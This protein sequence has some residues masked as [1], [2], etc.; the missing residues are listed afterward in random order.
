VKI[1]LILIAIIAASLLTGAIWPEQNGENSYPV[2]KV[3]IYVPSKPGGTT[4]TTARA[5]ARSL[6][7]HTGVKALVINQ[8]A[9]GGTVAVS[10]VAEARPD[11]GTLLLFH[12]MLHVSNATG[13]MPVSADDLTPLATISRASDVYVVRSDAPFDTLASLISHS[14][15]GELIIASQLGGT[16]Q[17][18]ASA[19]A[20]AAA[21]EGG[22]LRPVAMGSMAQRLTALLGGQVDVSIVDLK[23]ARQYLDAGSI[24]PL[25]VI[26]NKRDP[27]EPEWPTAIEQGVEID[28]AQVGEIYAPGGMNAESRHRMESIFETVL[29]DRQLV[30]D[31]A[32]VKQAVEYRNADDTLA[33][34]RS[35]RTRVSELLEPDS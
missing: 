13:Q 30:D 1:N 27:F 11:G 19:L 23:T 35:E 7:R 2:P 18:K 14:R 15:E 9:G 20:A 16:T 24:K 6:E 8:T 32:R 33:F 22:A 12:A 17:L 26:S 28:L 4:D 21:R 10:S 29:Q 34:I 31:L 25:A 3:K 5:F